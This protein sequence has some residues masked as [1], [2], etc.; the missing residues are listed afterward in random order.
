MHYRYADLIKYLANSR[1]QE[2]NDETRKIMLE[3]TGS[4]HFCMYPEDFKTFP[5]QDLHLIDHLWLKFS[6]GHFGFS[7]QKDIYINCGGV[8]DHTLQEEAEERFRKAGGWGNNFYDIQ[9]LPIKWDG[10]DPSG[11]LPCQGLIISGD[12]SFFRKS[13]QNNDKTVD[14]S[15]DI[16][17]SESNAAVDAIS[18][19]DLLVDEPDFDEDPT[20]F[21]T[22][23]IFGVVSRLIDCE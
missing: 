13:L 20:L 10:S 8:A 17:V 6:G 15:E 18:T 19:T 16:Y 5:C 14:I 22:A 11:Q 23:L 3:V 4:R 12:S 1:W 21:F 9:R 7:V 2:A